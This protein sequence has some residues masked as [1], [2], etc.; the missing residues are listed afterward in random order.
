[1]TDFRSVTISPRFTLHRQR[2]QQDVSKYYFSGQGFGEDKVK[3]FAF[4]Q[5]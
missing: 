5:V 1:M 2:Y 4:F 3:Q